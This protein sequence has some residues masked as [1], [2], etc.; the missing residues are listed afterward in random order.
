MG[1]RIWILLVVAAMC[2][3]GGCQI[4]TVDQIGHRNPNEL[5]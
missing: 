5:S 1:K 3:L 2:L 4:R